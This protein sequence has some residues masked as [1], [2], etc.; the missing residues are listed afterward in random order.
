MKGSLSA[1]CGGHTAKHGDFYLERTIKKCKTTDAATTACVSAAGVE[2]ASCAMEAVLCEPAGDEQGERCEYPYPLHAHS[3]PVE[4]GR[5]LWNV[6]TQRP[7]VS[8]LVKW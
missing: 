8:L 4:A 5:Y 7:A 3:F 2:A 6:L 1:C